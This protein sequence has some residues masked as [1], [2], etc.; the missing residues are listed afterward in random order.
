MSSEIGRRSRDGPNDRVGN[1]SFRN[2]WNGESGTV[3]ERRVGLG[4]GE[5]EK[6]RGEEKKHRR[7]EERTSVEKGKKDEEKIAVGLLNS[8]S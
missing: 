2:G 4:E 7:G 1:P 5:D 8:T 3:E 6:E